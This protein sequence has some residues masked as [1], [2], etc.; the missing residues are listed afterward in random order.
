MPPARWRHGLNHLRSTDNVINAERHLHFMKS[1]HFGSAQAPVG[2][3]GKRYPDHSKEATLQRQ[4]EVPVATAG[5]VGDRHLHNARED[6]WFS[7]SHDDEL[8]TGQTQ[9][10]QHTQS[11]S[12]AMSR[13]W[14]AL[15]WLCLAQAPQQSHHTAST[16]DRSLTCWMGVVR[17]LSRRLCTTGRASLSTA[18]QWACSA[19]L[20]SVAACRA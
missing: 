6:T 19:A 16:A 9:P 11:C 2:Q 18:W 14:A 7:S 15:E 10:N 5:A 13:W 1:C 17:L 4:V 20:E 12:L 8:L 3:S